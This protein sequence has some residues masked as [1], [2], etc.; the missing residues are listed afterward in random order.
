MKPTQEEQTDMKKMFKGV[1]QKLLD[2]IYPEKRSPDMEGGEEVKGYDFNNGVNYDEV[3]KTYKHTGIQATALGKAIDI[4]NSM[5]KWRLSDEPIAEDEDE[6]FKDPE[7]RANT[8]CTIFL[9]YTSNM[10]SCG[11]RDYIRFL[12][13]HKMVDCIVTTTGAIEEDFIKCMG[14]FYIGSFDLDGKE[15]RENSINRIGNMLVPNKNYE[16][17]EAFFLPIL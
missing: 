17:F 14:K 13:Q 3:F 10:I 15:L 9:G 2:S 16:N 11:M 5:I 4:V 6:E 1:P 12:C 7:V 8:R